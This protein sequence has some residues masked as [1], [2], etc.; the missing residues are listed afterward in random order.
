[1]H[2]IA[3]HRQRHRRREQSERLTELRRKLAAE[4]QIARCPVA[5]L[6]PNASKS[7]QERTAAR[8]RARVETLSAEIARMEGEG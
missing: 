1:M 3:R 8:A 2:D 5:I 4:Q 7:R 6:P